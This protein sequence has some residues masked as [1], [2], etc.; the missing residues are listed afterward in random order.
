MPPPDPVWRF[1]STK[2][3][4]VQSSFSGRRIH[5][6]LNSASPAVRFVDK[7]ILG[8]LHP[9]ATRIFRGSADLRFSTQVRLQNHRNADAA[10][11]ILIIFHHRN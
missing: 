11:G 5:R 8:L 3:P 9:G 1:F 6:E 4:D 7:G 2:K 10:I